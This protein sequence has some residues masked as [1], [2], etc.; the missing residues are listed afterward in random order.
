VAVDLGSK[1]TLLVVVAGTLSAMVVV[2]VKVGNAVVRRRT[3]ALLAE[4]ERDEGR[5]PPPQG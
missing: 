4:H 5:D 3:A 1:L 2:L